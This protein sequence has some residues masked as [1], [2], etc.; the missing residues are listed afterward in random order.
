MRL[1][2]TTVCMTPLADGREAVRIFPG[3]LPDSYSCWAVAIRAPRRSFGVRPA[4]HPCCPMLPAVPR[5]HPLFEHHPPAPR[6]P[7]HG[8][9]HARRPSLADTVSAAGGASSLGAAIPPGGARG[10]PGAAVRPV[11]SSTSETPHPSIGWDVVNFT[12]SSLAWR[13]SPWPA[14]RRANCIHDAQPYWS[15]PAA[16]RSAFSA[17]SSGLNDAQ[18]RRPMQ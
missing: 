12:A 8:N 5:I 18:K 9:R 16:C 17:R 4:S 7:G 13:A 14:V 15:D 2:A 3:C 10:A 11:C 6:L 1:S